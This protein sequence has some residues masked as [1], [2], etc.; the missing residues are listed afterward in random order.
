VQFIGRWFPEDEYQVA[1]LFLQIGMSLGVLLAYGLGMKLILI[2]ILLIFVFFFSAGGSSSSRS[3]SSI[4]SGCSA[5]LFFFFSRAGPIVIAN[6]GWLWLFV[7]TGTVGAVF[8]LLWS[9]VPEFPE[10]NNS[11]LFKLRC[12]FFLHLFPFFLFFLFLLIA[13]LFL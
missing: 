7:I 6:L 11:I 12:V 4:S 13:L 10:A 8:G 1:I 5:I 2:L 3:S 9:R